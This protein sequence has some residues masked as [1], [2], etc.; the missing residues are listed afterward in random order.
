MN[1]W[2]LASDWRRNGGMNNAMCWLVIGQNEVKLGFFL[3]VSI[4]LPRKEEKKIG[5]SNCRKKMFLEE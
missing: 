1:E 5:L 3:G 2:L 4:S